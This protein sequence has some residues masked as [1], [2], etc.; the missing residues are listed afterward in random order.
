MRVHDIVLKVFV[1]L[2]GT[3]QLVDSMDRVNWKFPG[4]KYTS[5]AEWPHADQQPGRNGLR[6]VQSYVALTG[7]E[8]AQHAGN[9]FYDKSHLLFEEMTKPFVGKVANDWFKLTPEQ[10]AAIDTEKYPLVK[11]NHGPGALVL[12]D[13]RT[14]HSPSDGTH[15]EN[16]RY[17]VYTCY[18]PYNPVMFTPED[19]KK[20]RALFTAKRAAPHWPTPQATPFP[21]FPR[22]FGKEDFRYKSVADEHLFAPCLK[23]CKSADE[24]RATLTQC[25]KPNAKEKLVFGFESYSARGKKGLWDKKWDGG[26][27]LLKLIA[28]RKKVPLDKEAIASLKKAKKAVASNHKTVGGD[29]K[30]RP[31]LKKKHSS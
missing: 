25:Q 1:T 5:Q 21:E 23:K 31:V 11:P 4:K 2:Y 22:T 13:S 24:R 30:A 19:E 27:P 9:R 16:G 14:I 8:T 28:D 20:K 15:Y 29:D 6:C 10:I 3:T 18:H 12:W 7:S 26:A 17:V